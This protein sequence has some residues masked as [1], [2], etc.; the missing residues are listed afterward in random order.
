M[1]L[2][3]RWTF[4]CSLNVNKYSLGRPQKGRKIVQ[5]RGSDESALSC[6][7]SPENRADLC[8]ASASVDF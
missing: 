5:L 2:R 6:A 8:Q 1:L 3:N 4:L 7:C